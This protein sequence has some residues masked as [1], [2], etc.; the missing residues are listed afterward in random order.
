MILVTG[1]TGFIGRELIRQL[2]KQAD[3]ANIL[4]LVYNKS[5]NELERSGRK[6]LD[7]LGVKYIPGDFVSGQ[8]L[9]NI[10]KSPEMV[11]HMASKTITAEKNHSIN[12]IGTKN[13]IEAIK[14][15]KPGMHFIFTS[16]IC[17]N[18]RRPDYNKPITE[19]E[20]PPEK[21]ANEYGRTKLLAENYLKK[22]GAEM[23]FSLSIIRVCAVYGEG[24]RKNGLF[25]SIEKMVVRKNLLS[26]LNWPGKISIINVKDMAKFLIHV[27]SAPPGTT[28]PEI[29]IPSIEALTM[30]EMSNSL[31]TVYG[32][33]YSP[34]NL[35]SF[36]WNICRF[37]ARKKHLVEHFLPHSLYDKYWQA[38]ILVNNEFWN[39]SE[40]IYK[41]IPGWNPVMYETFYLNKKMGNQLEK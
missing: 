14:P 15:I 21:P 26:R 19:T 35:P 30:A 9:E 23:N 18:D 41:V 6:N 2:V 12:D 7:D 39:H 13:L 32:I 4:C 3:K 27:S 40:K 28:S 16:T 20:T 17:V 5:D 8:G 10:P 33:T 1:A 25:D 36:F 37:F 34:T 22:C 24:A 38:C 11:F 31:H 29:Y